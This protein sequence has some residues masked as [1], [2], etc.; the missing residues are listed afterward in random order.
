M[1]SVAPDRRL[2]AILEIGKLITGPHDL[3]SVLRGIVSKA[4]GVMGT[5][6][7]SLYLLDEAKNELELRATKGLSTQSVGRVRM[8]VG[9]G[10]TGLAVERMRPVA[11]ADAGRHPKY[12]F[13]PLTH[14]EKF[15]SFLAVPLI[16]KHRPVGALVVQTRAARTFTPDEVNLLS[17]IAT[18]VVGVVENAQSRPSRGSSRAWEGPLGSGSAVPRSSGG[19]PR[20]IRRACTR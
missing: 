8:K 12:K 5:D 20:P 6:V 1:K 15:H 19:G 10:L 4:A 17:A 11:V 18:Q 9:E 2:K 13:F 16:D 7:A 3:D 14:E